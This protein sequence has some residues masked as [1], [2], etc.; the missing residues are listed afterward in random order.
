MDTQK[1]RRS[2]VFRFR[3]FFAFSYKEKRISEIFLLKYFSDFYIRN[4]APS[5]AARGSNKNHSRT[6]AQDI[7][8]THACEMNIDEN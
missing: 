2:A 7:A 1:K 8:R 4:K 5:R 3:A 6:H